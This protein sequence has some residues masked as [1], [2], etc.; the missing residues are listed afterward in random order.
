MLKSIVAVAT[1]GVALFLAYKRSRSRPRRLTAS[2]Y[3]RDPKDKEFGV[4]A[5][6]LLPEGQ[7]QL[8]SSSQAGP[9]PS[10]FDLT[11]EG[12]LVL[13][14]ETQ[15]T[16]SEPTGQVSSFVVDTKTRRL[17]LINRQPSCGKDPCHIVLVSTN[18]S[19][20]AIVA[21]YSSGSVAVL[22]IRADGHIESPTQSIQFEGKS[23]HERQEASHAHQIVVRDSNVHPGS[24]IVMVVDLGGDCVHQFLLSK[25]GQLISTGVMRTIDGHGPR[26]MALHPRLPVYYLANELGNAVSCHR[27]LTTETEER[28]LP[29][30]QSLSS[31]PAGYKP[32]EGVQDSL[33]DIHTSPDGLFLYASNRGHDSIVTYKIDSR[34][35]SL[36]LVGH[37]STRGKHPRNF[38]IDSS[39]EFLVV[40]NQDTHSLV[41]FHR[42]RTSGKLSFTGNALTLPYPVCLKFLDS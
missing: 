2:S 24:K 35:G 36:S 6:E 30:F 42:D 21:N 4:W 27:F 15:S 23:V 39:G 33:A 14:N 7:L 1:A 20:F 9:N 32:A 26:H 29:A 17:T 19:Q 5:L 37:E 8:V 11:S 10:F 34:D 40:A 31:L 12:H 16:G 13:V 28:L 22:P 18:G 3:T 25:Q 38:Q 41:S